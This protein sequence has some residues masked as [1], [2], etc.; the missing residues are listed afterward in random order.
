MEKFLA[1]AS[2]ERDNALVK[3]L[4]GKKNEGEGSRPEGPQMEVQEEKPVRLAGEVEMYDLN[5]QIKTRD[6]ENRE[7]AQQ[8]YGRVQW[9]FVAVTLHASVVYMGS[10]V[11]RVLT[12]MYPIDHI[13]LL[14]G[15]INISYR[16]LFIGYYMMRYL[17]Q[18]V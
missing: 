8:R 6:V 1:Y 18:S 16:L 13:H 11:L 10:T 9:E 2:R 15:Y 7:L 5:R 4:S 14:N 17:A 12:Y 3:I